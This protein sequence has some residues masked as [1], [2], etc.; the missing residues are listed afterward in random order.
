MRHPCDEN[1]QGASGRDLVQAQDEE[2]GRTEH[3]GLVD[4]LSRRDTPFQRENG[5]VQKGDEYTVRLEEVAWSVETSNG[6][7]QR[8]L[9]DSRVGNN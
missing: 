1:G 3:E 6:P 7:S 9:K 2:E 4:V 5:F 8:N